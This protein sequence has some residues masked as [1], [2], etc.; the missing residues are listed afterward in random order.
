MGKRKYKRRVRKLA[1]LGAA[2]SL[3]GAVLSPACAEQRLPPTF[4][5]GA[6]DQ[7][8]IQEQALLGLS[9]QG[10]AAAVQLVAAEG[11]APEL[12]LLVFDHKGGPTRVA[13]KASLKV[14]RAVAA[15]VLTLGDRPASVLPGVLALEWPEVQAMVADLGFV[16]KP[17]A[18]PEP[19]RR[20]W[21]LTG[22][23]ATGS[24]PLSVR[25]A[26]VGDSPRSIA[27]L[28]SARPGGLTGGDEVELARMPLSGRAITAEVW[29]EAGTAWLVAGSVD[30]TRPLHRAVGLRRGSVFRGEAEL[31]NAHGLADYAAGELDA[32]AR[33]FDRAIAAD[34][35]FV[36]GFYN[37]A[38]AAALSDRMSDAVDFLR[39]AVH[40]DP[41]RVQVLGRDDDDLALLRRR[42]DVRALL[43]L[44]RPPPDDAAP[45]APAK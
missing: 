36:D 26:E 10:D 40:L 3:A 22:A 45:D 19:G 31:H 38:S 15:R 34:D 14:A 25:I 35:T 30:S 44:R 24:L 32:A 4:P 12:T 43:G 41:A 2:L 39:S 8:V 18:V 11:N 1:S 21:E 28:L 42:P 20:R 33:E 17:P 5:L 9:P 29:I 23:D 37:A 16:Q 27:L 6:A 7:P 13:G